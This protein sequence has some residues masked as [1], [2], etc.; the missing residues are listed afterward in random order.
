VVE[1]VW[2]KFHYQEKYL[3]LVFSCLLNTIGK[4]LAAGYNP[5]YLGLTAADK[6]YL[7]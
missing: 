2:K 5:I 1:L 7:L 3:L 4:S 6:D